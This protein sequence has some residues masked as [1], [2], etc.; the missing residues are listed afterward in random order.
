[1]PSPGTVAA[2]ARVLKLPMQE[3]LALQRTVAE[4]SGTVTADGP[5]RPIG[6]WEPHITHRHVQRLC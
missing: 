2:L 4:E 5:G 1:M 3:L 6:E